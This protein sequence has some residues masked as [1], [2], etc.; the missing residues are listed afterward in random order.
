[1]SYRTSYR[2]ELR[3]E[4]SGRV[5]FKVLQASARQL[6][7]D[8]HRGCV[9]TNHGSRRATRCRNFLRYSSR[10]A[11]DSR[12]DPITAGPHG[13]TPWQ[14]KDSNL[15]SFRDGFTDQ[16]QQPRDQPKRLSPNNFRAYSPQTA[17]DLRLQLDTSRQFASTASHV[18]ITSHPRPRP[19]RHE[20]NRASGPL[21]VRRG[22]GLRTPPSRHGT[23]V[24][25]TAT[26]TGSP[27]SQST[28]LAL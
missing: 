24:R 10:T 12:V 5:M 19:C 11:V 15:R 28:R 20:R 6:D 21:T 22:R 13:S 18:A 27:R 8:T 4:S 25:L 23:S 26:R 3:S 17:D 9:D 14:V 1:M 2:T 16:R 7:S